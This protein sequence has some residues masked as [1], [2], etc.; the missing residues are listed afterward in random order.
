MRP[1]RLLLE[2]FL[3]L[4]FLLL[5]ASLGAL[6]GGGLMLGQGAIQLWQ[7]VHLLSSETSHGGAKAASVLVLH[8]IDAF[9]FAVVQFVIGYAIT[10]SFVIDLPPELRS[11]V[12]LWMQA[13]GVSQLKHT[14][15]EVV[16]LALVIDFATDAAEMEARLEWDMLVLPI[17]IVLIAAALRLMTTESHRK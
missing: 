5:L 15:I 14:L 3:S 2:A 9:L 13:Q 16:L 7:A 4:R 1:M 17:A 11:R 12:P 8:G 10:F 6:L